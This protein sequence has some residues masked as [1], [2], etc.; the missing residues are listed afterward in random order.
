MRSFASLFVFALCFFEVALALPAPMPGNSKAVAKKSAGNKKANVHHTTVPKK[1]SAATKSKTK[2]KS[3]LSKSKT[4][5][6][7][8]S[9]ANAP[10][11]P[12]KR[13]APPGGA[14]KAAPGGGNKRASPGK[15][16][17]KKAPG[18]KK[19]KVKRSDDE[20]GFTTLGRRTGSG[21]EFLGFHGTT[22]STAAQYTSAGRTGKHLPILS[23]GFNGAD[24]ELGPGLYVTDHVETAMFFANSGAASRKLKDASIKPMVCMVE[25]MTSSAW[26]TGTP[27]LW[28]PHDMVAKSKGGKND[29]AILKQ[30]AD[31]ATCAGLKPEETVR[32]SVLDLVNAAAG[33]KQVTGNQFAI[34]TTQFNK[35]YIRSCLDITGKGEKDVL[36]YF[37]QQGWPDHD[38]NSQKLRTDWAI[39][40]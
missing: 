11:C 37:E 2:S 9:G 10:S 32:F 17:P 3:S 36:K 40:A 5:S 13:P 28:I 24:A 34:P 27:K 1:K 8:G 6:S 25:A 26:R 14:K 12:L 7:L 19:K 33:N 38:F 22:S 21:S 39:Y 15:G 35:I 16:N 31:L 4:T 23:S 30:Q 18:G 20:F 29:P